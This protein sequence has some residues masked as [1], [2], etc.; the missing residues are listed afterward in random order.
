EV[1]AAQATARA[2]A[3]RTQEFTVRA[4][5]ASIVLARPIDAGQVV[6]TTT[7]LFELGAASGGEIEAEV[8]EAYGD[9]IRPGMTA[10]VAATGS[11][12]VFAG[13]VSEVSP[14]VDASTGGRLVRLTYDPRAR[15]I[16]GRSVDV[17]IIVRPAE[18]LILAPRDAVV[19]ATVDPKVY[20]VREDG[21]VGV[22][23]VRIA[24]W[25]STNAIVESGLS[26]GDRI[27]LRPETVSQG[28]RVRPKTAR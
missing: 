21:T 8:D 28:E 12:E 17:T 15:L 2:A 10:R 14:Q 3:Q 19:D 6:A 16:P 27:V 5:T 4:P 26:A 20:I 11:K 22:R 1:A 24:D 18:T 13:T 7:T 25:P 9:A 23:R